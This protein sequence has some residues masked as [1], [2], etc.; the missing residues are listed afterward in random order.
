MVVREGVTPL[1][2]H[3]HG[4]TLEIMAEFALGSAERFGLHRPRRRRPAD[5][6]RVR[7]PIGSLFVDRTAA[8]SGELH[9][10]FPAVHHGP[11]VAEDGR[12]RLRIYV[13]AASVEVFGGRG[14]CVLTD[15]IFPDNDSRAC[16]LFAEGG[17]VTVSYLDVK[18]P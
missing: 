2:G 17:D 7:H 11:L 12:V 5:G 3:A 10:A 13:D 18:H 8:G 1:P 6:C 16:S 15:Q 4:E 9:E 14:E